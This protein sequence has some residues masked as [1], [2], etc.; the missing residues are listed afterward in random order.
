M[1]V[2]SVVRIDKYLKLTRLIK[3]RTVAKEIVDEGVIFINGHKAKPAKEVKV[4]DI[5]KLQLGK[6]QLTIKVLALNPV[7]KKDNADEMYEIL[8]DKVINPLDEA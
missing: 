2:V 8:E 7:T 6:H 3:R 4:G 5:V 1:L